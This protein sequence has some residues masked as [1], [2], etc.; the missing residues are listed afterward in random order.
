MSTREQRRAE[1]AFGCVNEFVKYRGEDGKPDEDE[2]QYKRFAK[3]FPALL[4]QSGLAQALAFAESKAPAG[5]L[6]NLATVIDEG[7]TREELCNKARTASLRD[8]RFYSREAMTA[9]SWLKRY[10]EALL[11]GDE[12]EESNND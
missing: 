3:R 5:Y 10:A 1:E 11:S 4:H 12:D 7:L 6:D 2:A 8:Y 9:A